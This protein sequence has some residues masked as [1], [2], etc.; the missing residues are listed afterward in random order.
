MMDQTMLSATVHA[1]MATSHRKEI[2]SNLKLNMMTARASTSARGARSL[3]AE[4]AEV[5]EARERVKGSATL[6]IEL[7]IRVLSGSF[8]VIAQMFATAQ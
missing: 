7:S 2:K 4:V 5:V 1:L 3:A 8:I 6:I